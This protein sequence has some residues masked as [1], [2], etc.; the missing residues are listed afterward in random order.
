MSRFINAVAALALVASGAAIATAVAVLRPG[1]IANLREAVATS[2]P[3]SVNRNSE[4][5]ADAVV[6][7]DVNEGGH[8]HFL[9]PHVSIRKVLP[10]GYQDASV[11]VDLI[12]GES[13]DVLSAKAVSGVKEHFREAEKLARRVK[14]LPFRRNGK[15]VVARIEGFRVEVFP[16]ETRPDYPVPFPES[17]DLS[18]LAIKMIR[19]GGEG[20]PRTKLEVLGIGRVTY[21][22]NSAAIKGKH[23]ATVDKAEVANLV[24]LLKRHQVFSL[25]SAYV[26]AW[27]HQPVVDL[28]VSFGGRK[29]RIWDYRGREVGMPDAVLD[30][31]DAIDRTA[32]VDRWRLGN[33]E[34]VPTLLQ[35]KWDFKAKT[36]ANEGLLAG[37][38]RRGTA[39]LLRELI[40]LGAP[41]VTGPEGD[42]PLVAAA[43]R[44]D[45]DIFDE[46]MAQK[47]KWSDV[48][49]GEA[50]VAAAEAG[51]ETFAVDLLWKGANP[52]YQNRKMSWSSRTTP[53]IAA[54]DVASLDVVELL[55]RWV[56]K[57]MGSDFDPLSEPK[58]ASK[59]ELAA[60]LNMADQEGK[61]ALH[62]AIDGR[63]DTEF[64]Y[65]DQEKRFARRRAVVAA[66]LQAGADPNARDKRGNAPLHTNRRDAAIAR[67]LLAAGA[68]VNARDKSGRTALMHCYTPELARV[69][70]EAG[71]GIDAK[72]DEGRTAIDHARRI[73]DAD[74]VAF[75][76]TW[77]RTHPPKPRDVR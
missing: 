51:K 35:E 36:A 71:A 77:R 31:Q 18:S 7:R 11:A 62:W 69:L 3:P 38:A 40:A 53:L 66:L 6:I 57:R 10:P 22:S 39:T 59:A 46:L 43:T 70:L 28:E 26:S 32:R 76:K 41:I 64:G 50:L 1:W 55:I 44:G 8:K 20:W 58:V 13:G 54:A 68:D 56:T 5:Y 14:Y 9:G 61:T 74:V 37:V 21:E 67:Q 47:V 42:I 29:V 24:A 65:D 23:T 33:E 34:T 15:P 2:T 17:G 45:E 49:L 60:F 63:G 73:Q 30:I 27:T 19:I 12:V 52:K 75:L 4:R 16:P 25:K 72:D 48:A